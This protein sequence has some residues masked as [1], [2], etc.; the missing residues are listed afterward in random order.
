MTAEA[1]SH[2]SPR[3]PSLLDAVAPI[4]V[5]I[6]LLALTIALFGIGATDGPLQVALLL[7]PAMRTY[8]DRGSESSPAAAGG[9]SVP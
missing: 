3:E 5:L 4:V 6:G 9:F 1:Q 8:T 7:T 2:R